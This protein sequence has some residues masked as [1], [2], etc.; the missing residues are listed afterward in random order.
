[1]EPVSHFR[2]VVLFASSLKCGKKRVPVETETIGCSS[3]HKKKTPPTKKQQ[4]QNPNVN[5]R[6]RNEC[7][8]LYIYNYTKECFPLETLSFHGPCPSS[9]LVLEFHSVK[10]CIFYEVTILGGTKSSAFFV[11]CPCTPP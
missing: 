10:I 9:T 2:S 11:L 5:N 4:Q 1:M 3:A 7:E 8:Q 6:K